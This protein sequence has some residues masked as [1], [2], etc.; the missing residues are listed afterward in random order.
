MSEWDAE[1]SVTIRHGDAAALVQAVGYGNNL[2]DEAKRGAEVIKR[3]LEEATYEPVEGDEPVSFTCCNWDKLSPESK[4]AVEGVVRA[5]AGQLDSPLTE[6][7]RAM[8]DAARQSVVEARN[9]PLPPHPVEEGGGEDEVRIRRCPTCERVTVDRPVEVTAA[10]CFANWHESADFE[11]VATFHGPV[12]VAVW[13]LFGVRQLAVD[14]EL[15]GEVLA[16][17]WESINEAIAERVDDALKKLSSAHPQLSTE[18]GEGA[19]GERIL[20]WLKSEDAFQVANAAVV[21]LNWGGDKRRKEMTC[22]Q[23]ARDVVA[24]L[25]EYLEPLLVAPRGAPGGTDY[26]AHLHEVVDA[27]RSEP[28]TEQRVH[29]KRFVPATPEPE[30]GKGY[31]APTPEITRFLCPRCGAELSN[32][33]VSGAV[34]VKPPLCSWG[35]KPTEMEQVLVNVAPE[36]EEGSG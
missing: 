6:E 22:G 13:A 30:E 33:T 23:M 18:E 7:E 4:R 32:E 29:A 21:K 27:H 36:P 11:T 34:V 35:H 24:A 5:A 1:I 2:S 9:A 20:R 25:T 14:E 16:Q 26:A 12:A 15:Q 3:V 28:S 17:R 31:E 10:A 19:R 8:Y